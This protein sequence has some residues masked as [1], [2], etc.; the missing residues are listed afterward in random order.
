M[1]S[2]SVVTIS[3]SV[4]SSLRRSHARSLPIAQLG[5]AYRARTTSRARAGPDSALA[6]VTD[7]GRSTTVSM[8]GGE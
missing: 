8:A 2:S 7:S 4:V 6:T 5:N 3:V 1:R